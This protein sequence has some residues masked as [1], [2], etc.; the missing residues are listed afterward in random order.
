[1][2]EKS[3]ANPSLPL[4]VILTVITAMDVV[5][6][7]WRLSL[8]VLTPLSRS[9]VAINFPVVI[10]TAVMAAHLFRT[11]HTPACTSGAA[12]DRGTPAVA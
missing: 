10:F 8:K 11:A 7:W 5:A 12:A 4:A 3:S 6:C 9:L 2:T 1:M